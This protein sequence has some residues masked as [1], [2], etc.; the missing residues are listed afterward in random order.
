[1]ILRHP[2]ATQRSPETSKACLCEKEATPPPPGESLRWGVDDSDP[3]EGSILQTRTLDS[4]L[5][6]PI[7][8]CFADK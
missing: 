7:S 5:Y 3:G 6:S 4:W 8:G 2:E 1:M